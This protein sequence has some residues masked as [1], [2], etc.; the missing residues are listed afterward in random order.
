[1]WVDGRNETRWAASRC[2]DRI[3]GAHTVVVNPPRGYAVDPGPIAAA[4]GCTAMYGETAV[5]AP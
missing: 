2:M 3:T 1:V 4:D 5:W